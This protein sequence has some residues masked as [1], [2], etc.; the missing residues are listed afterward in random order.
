LLKQIKE[1]MKLKFFVH[2]QYCS[3]VV[4]KVYY[5]KGTGIDYFL[6]KDFTGFSQIS[7]NHIFDCSMDPECEM[8]A[9]VSNV[10]VKKVEDL[11]YF[12]VCKT[13]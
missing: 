9:S 2:D 5:L 1:G 3:F 7:T 6:F 13:L 11:E 4:D 12:I 8:I 10:K